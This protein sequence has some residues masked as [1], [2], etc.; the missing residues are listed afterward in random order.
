MIYGQGEYYRS[1]DE[2]LYAITSWCL[3]SQEST[4]A[5]GRERLG[6]GPWLGTLEE[7]RARLVANP[8]R[9]IR[10]GYPAASVAWNLGLRDDVDSICWWNPHGVKISDDGETFYGAN[11]GQR[12][13]PYLEEAMR[14]IRDDP[15]TTRAWVPVW[16]PEDMIDHTFPEMYAGSPPRRSTYYSRDGKDVPCT[17]GFGLHVRQFFGSSLLD[18]EVVMRSQSAWAVFPYDL[19]LFTVLQELI[20][21]ELGLGLGV[22]HWMAVNAHVYVTEE[23]WAKRGV[24]AYEEDREAGGEWEARVH[25]PISLTLGEAMVAYP[26]MMD[27]FHRDDSGFEIPDDPVIREMERGAALVRHADVESG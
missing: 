15:G 6:G 14:L 27:K 26:E 12:F 5:R 4:V 3:G 8:V 17:L 11:Y 16:R 19:Y 2:M 25:G 13:M 18:M 9:G 10:E 20:A 7:P 21:N 22:T 24:K 23:H 1:A